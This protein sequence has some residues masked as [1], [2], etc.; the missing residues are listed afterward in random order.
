MSGS[1]AFA[2]LQIFPTKERVCGKERGIDF[3]LTICKIDEMH[4][5]EL[6]GE[7]KIS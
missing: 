7:I 3:P 1:G 6:E 4:S 2:W 5:L